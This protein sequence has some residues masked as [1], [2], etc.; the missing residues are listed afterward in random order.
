MR[1]RDVQAPKSWAQDLCGEEGNNG[2]GEGDGRGAFL[3]YRGLGG[4]TWG[5]AD[6]DGMKEID[7]ILTEFQQYHD[8]QRQC[9]GTGH[10]CVLHITG[11]HAA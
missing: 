10:L 3:S 6:S 5:D 4:R 1:G 9:P 11:L 8:E 7:S 2:A